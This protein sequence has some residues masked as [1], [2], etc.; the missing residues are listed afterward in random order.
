M[1]NL[2]N[3]IKNFSI[4]KNKIF[5]CSRCGKALGED[6]VYASQFTLLCFECKNNLNF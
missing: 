6:E 4:N 5:Y 2:I 3:N 1:M